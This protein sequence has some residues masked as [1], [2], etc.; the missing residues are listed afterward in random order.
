[1]TLRQA[2]LLILTS[3]VAIFCSFIYGLYLGDYGCKPKCSECW[4]WK[5]ALDKLKRGEAADTGDPTP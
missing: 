3:L 2:A 1:M 5:K 4:R